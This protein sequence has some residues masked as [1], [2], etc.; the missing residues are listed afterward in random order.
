MVDFGLS[1]DQ[2][3]NVKKGEKL[4]QYQ[5]LAR[6]LKKMSSKKVTVIR[7]AVR[8]FETIFKNNRKEQEGTP[9]NERKKRK[10]NIKKK[11]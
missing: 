10:E 11:L 5:D 9:R 4:V 2:K 7:I 3:V 1:V 6:G 8:V